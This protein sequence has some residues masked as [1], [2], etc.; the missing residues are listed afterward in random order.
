[1]LRKPIREVVVIWTT[2]LMRLTPFCARF[3]MQVRRYF[4]C[5]T[6]S[7]ASSIPDRNS[8]IR[9]NDRSTSK[10]DSK[11]FIL[12]VPAACLLA[13]SAP[14]S[15]IFLPNSF[16]AFSITADAARE[17]TASD[18]CRLSSVTMLNATV[19]TTVMQ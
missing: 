2:T 18:Q 11:S 3:L 19:A 17:S 6:W 10:P 16:G 8:F 14:N 5:S 9:P 13:Q 4:G 15:S 7:L 12:L 1:M